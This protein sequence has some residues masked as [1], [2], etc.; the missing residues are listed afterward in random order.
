MIHVEDTELKQQEVV[1]LFMFSISLSLKE[2]KL[3]EW[4]NTKLFHITGLS[5]VIFPRIK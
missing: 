1:L 2:K 3:L 4:E 5:G